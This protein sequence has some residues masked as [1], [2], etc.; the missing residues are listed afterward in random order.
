M[1]WKTVM[2][3][4]LISWHSG[5]TEAGFVEWLSNYLTNSKKDPERTLDRLAPGIINYLT[6][7]KLSEQSQGDN[8]AS[9]ETSNGEGIETDEEFLHTTLES[10]SG[11]DMLYPSMIPNE[12]TED[13]ELSP[14][15]IPKEGTE[16]EEKSEEKSNI[17]DQTELF[18]TE[19]DIM[20]NET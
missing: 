11:K 13:I 7:V 10:T 20:T 18:W 4:I 16:V 2:Y 19:S 5:H 17:E 8:E 1:L 3:L 15:D 14:A 6:K 12:N 9:N